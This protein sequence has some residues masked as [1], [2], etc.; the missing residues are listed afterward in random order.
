MFCFLFFF[1]AFWFFSPSPAS[2]RHVGPTGQD[3]PAQGVPD[4]FKSAEGGHEPLEGVC[5]GRVWKWGTEP[6]AS[7]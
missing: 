5:L 7:L 3:V 6:A 2:L 1:N 4:D